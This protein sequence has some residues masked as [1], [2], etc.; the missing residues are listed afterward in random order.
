[1]FSKKRAKFVAIFFSIF[2]LP[3]TNNYYA[4]IYSEANTALDE[5]CHY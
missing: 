2:G 3:T 1:M 4:N 5:Q